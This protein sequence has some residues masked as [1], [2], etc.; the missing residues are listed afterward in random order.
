VRLV[1]DSLVA[2]LYGLATND[3]AHIAARFPIYDRDAGDEHRYPVLAAQVYEAFCGEGIAGAERR[4]AELVAA[5]AAAGI[6]FGLDELWRP[7]GGWER[8]NREAR[9]ILDDDEQAA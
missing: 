6:G 9:E 3:F 2:D 8:A 5:R 1:L 7:D 4:A